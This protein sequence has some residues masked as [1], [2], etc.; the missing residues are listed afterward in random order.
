MT[1][2]I[3][4]VGPLLTGAIIGLAFGLPKRNA[5]GFILTLGGAI[6]GVIAT[7]LLLDHWSVLLPSVAA[8]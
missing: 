1:I 6:C 8:K 7:A 5:Y 4:K 3:L 2:W